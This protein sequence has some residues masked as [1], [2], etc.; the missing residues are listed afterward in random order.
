MIRYNTNV[1]CDCF[2]HKELFTI[3]WNISH[4][5]YNTVGYVSL[6]FMG[7]FILTVFGYVFMKLS[8]KYRNYRD[9]KTKLESKPRI[10][11][12]AGMS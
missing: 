2:L 11:E 8:S 6:S 4:S 10:V 9:N 5:N 1:T 7:L 12:G 3:E